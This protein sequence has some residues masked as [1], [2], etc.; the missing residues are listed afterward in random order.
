VL[1]AAGVCLQA[2][3][4]SRPAAAIVG[5]RGNWTGQ[6]PDADPPLRWTK[7]SKPMKA[8]R[9]RADKPADEGPAGS[10]AYEGS[11]REWL[12][13]GPFAADEDAQKAIDA[14]FL[15]DEAACQP[16]AGE[17]AAKLRWKKVEVPGSMVDF[18][19]ILAG[20]M[21]EDAEARRRDKHLSPEYGKPFVAYAHTYVYSAIDASFHFR[22]KALNRAKI[23]ING[24]LV[25]AYDPKRTEGDFTA[26]LR[27]GWNRVLLK[28]RNDVVP[29][30]QNYYQGLMGYSSWY[31]DLG[32]IPPRPYETES[33]GIAWATP[34]PSYHIA[35]PLIVGDRVFVM[36]YPGDLVCVRKSDGKVLWI[37]PTTYWD[38]LSDEDKKGNA[39]FAAVEPLVAEM[40][41]IDTPYVEKASLAEDTIKKRASLHQQITAIMG[42]ADRKY[43]GE[44][45]HYVAAN[46]PT[47][48]SDGK[49]VYVWSE[50]GIATCFDLDGN[51]KWIRMPG[52]RECSV[53]RYA[54]PVLADGKF[55]LFDGPGHHEQDALVALDARTG[56][57]AWTMPHDPKS[58]PFSSL[59]ATTLAGEEYVI[60]GKDLVR[61]RD[62][63]VLLENPPA[64]V[65]HVAT[66][67]VAG[68]V[69]YG[70]TCDAGDVIQA[71]LPTDLAKAAMT[72]EAK[73]KGLG[74]AQTKVGQAFISSPLY[75]DGLLYLVDQTGRLHV[76]D[77]DTQKIVYE[78]DLGM[79]KVWPYDFYHAPNWE[80]ST[81][82]SSPIL[83]GKYVY[84]F[85]MNGTT[86][87]FEAG[88][89]YKEVARNKIE[90][91]LL[92]H[93]GPWF[94]GR[95]IPEFFASSPV[96]E[97]K[98]IYVRGGNYL[99]CL[100]KAPGG[101]R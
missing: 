7:V 92:V 11:L 93:Q 84:V 65:C 59:I 62:G 95:E 58:E 26:K 100:G 97:G 99:Y 78:R 53:G 40:R 60:Y 81:T 5:W 34:V 44:V 70:V 71:K 42:K 63:K 15:D 9:C 4:Q 21:P 13:L 41:Q 47:P 64:L 96:A 54:S 86:V 51:R 68:G 49:N 37:R 56:E 74:E 35:C 55:I 101:S 87:V 30:K 90:D 32:L 77:T 85:G 61:A 8:L 52:V 76:V 31:V 24:E 75:H 20:D 48:V 36:A 57:A 14:P 3:A 2:S 25:M 33:E 6:F 83:A 94:Q 19:G 28:A 16:S 45:G 38:V 43:K 22:T 66:P 79:G 23:F 39:A 88:R 80:R 17:A 73:V 67:V 72:N 82:L 27:K 69:M 91:C 50:L 10:P 46:M 1:L 12:V 89:E 98:R 29:A 18:A